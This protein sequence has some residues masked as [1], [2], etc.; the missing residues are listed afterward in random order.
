MEISLKANF[1]LRDSPW[2]L[3]DEAQPIFELGKRRV[4]S[5]EITLAELRSTNAPIPKGIIPNLEE[6]PKW[7][8]LA[9]ILE[10]ID[11]EQYLNPQ[12]KGTSNNAILI[13]CSSDETCEQLRQYLKDLDDRSN[14]GEDLTADE[15]NKNS[16]RKLL[17]RKLKTYFYW[18]KHFSVIQQE[19]AKK[20][21]GPI[22]GPVTERPAAARHGRQPPNKRRRV[23]GASNAA[24]NT[25]RSEQVVSAAPVS[26]MTSMAHPNTEGD[27]AMAEA[28][29][30]SLYVDLTDEIEPLVENFDLI[31]D[32]YELCDMDDLII[33]HKY[34]NEQDEQLLEE[35]KPRY[36][37]M[38]EPKVDFVRR[39]EVYRSSH[40]ERKVKVYTL[41]YEN[42]VEE[43][44]YLSNLRFEKD[45]FSKLIRE[46]GQMALTLDAK[47]SKEPSEDLLRIINTR[48]AGGGRLAA[49]SAQPLV[50]VDIREFRSHLPA[51]LHGKLKIVPNLLNVGDYVLTPDI[52]VE[53]KSIA[54]LIGSF[55]DG[56][57]YTQCENMTLCY[58]RPMLLIEMG[59]GANPSLDIVQNQP[60]SRDNDLPQDSVQGKL[61]LLA[62]T[63]KSL[64]I[65]WSTSPAHTA[66]IFMM[67]KSGQP[68]PDPVTAARL[69]TDN[70]IAGGGKR[71]YNYTP[72]E[73][74]RKVP[75]VDAGDVF[76]VASQFQNLS[77]VANATERELAEVVG[78]ER[79]GKIHRF[80]TRKF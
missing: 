73:M 10:E 64:Q 17:L 45:A 25:A 19:N 50:V 71:L 7:R 15:A 27:E 60:N 8:V 11:R 31:Q 58:K 6:P 57:L 14:K 67:L 55:N 79:A 5:G 59:E 16:A 68:E 4:Y 72:V 24:S 28:L 3:L 40:P 39:I 22:N 47:A 20:T 18:K 34:N 30:K 78:K 52:C 69:G 33:V 65:I 62:L 36:V 48:I 46:K 32:F 61:A 23:R 44:S 9:E 80:F 12:P 43:K 26:P 2:L 56:R 75:G 63:F 37:I 1:N 53:R 42:S 51:L 21:Y 13:M 54:D 29:Q 76:T 41:Y 49:T 38:Y 35:V 74:L 66:E 77:M 70:D